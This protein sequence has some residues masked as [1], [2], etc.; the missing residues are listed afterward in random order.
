MNH[1]EARII[2]L[3][4]EAAPGRVRHA[5]AATALATGTTSTQTIGRFDREVQFYLA[6]LELIEPL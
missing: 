4:A 2:G 3:V 1:V 5:R 6:Y